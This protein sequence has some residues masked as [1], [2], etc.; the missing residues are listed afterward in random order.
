MMV[1]TAWRAAVPSVLLAL[2]A[3]SEAVA[4]GIVGSRFFP[5]TFAI[6]DPFPSDF[7]NF[8]GFLVLPESAAAPPTRELDF[9]VT[10][11]KRI[12]SDWS[13]T[14]NETYRILN[15]P[16]MGLRTGFNNLLIGTK[17][18]IYTN[19]EHEFFFSVGGTAL[20]GGTGSRRVGAT[21]F[22]TLTPTVY[23]AKGFGDL[24]DSL[25]WLRPVGI[26]AAVGVAVPTRSA[27]VSTTTLPTGATA[28]AET[29][30]PTILQWGF[31][32]EY[33]LV[34]PGRPENNGWG[35]LV[36]LVE[37]ALQTPLNGPNSGETTG[38]INPGIVWVDR[39]LEVGLE[40]VIPV[41]ARSGRD[42]GFRAQ[43][44]LFF[45]DIFPN[46]LGKPIF[47]N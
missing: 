17:Y 44:H 23:A 15:Q 2:A 3:S 26:T 32:L 36:P 19:A 43:M 39:Y 6:I 27:T 41:N 13:V 31:A 10:W 46:T 47:G 28:I 24:P 45:D 38:T 42:I 1:R 16:T 14:F 12:T 21:S 18:Q 33:S 40:A 25:A 20:V 5:S 34:T 37:F 35:G 29:I 8:P 30:N 11:S 9:P 22:S 7:L 4:H